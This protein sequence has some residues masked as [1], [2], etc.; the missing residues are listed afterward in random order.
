MEQK[1]KI[2]RICA[3][4]TYKEKKN[5][6]EFKLK[7][8][9][10]QKNPTDFLISRTYTILPAKCE[11]FLKKRGDYASTGCKQSKRCKFITKL[12]D[13]NEN[14]NQKAFRTI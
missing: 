6:A 9:K 13:K 1:T 11:R 5:N 7:K 4:E 2:H 10:K 14:S 12:T 3:N 8:N